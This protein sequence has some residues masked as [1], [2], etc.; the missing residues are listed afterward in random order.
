LLAV[1]L[2]LGR[3]AIWDS[4][5][6]PWLDGSY[7]KYWTSFGCFFHRLTNCTYPSKE[8]MKKAKDIESDNR[9]IRIVPEMIKS[10]FYPK[11]FTELLECAPVVSKKY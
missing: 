8:E 2:D 9:V 7:C 10:P 4:W 5:I 11:M 1:A 6:D 3:I